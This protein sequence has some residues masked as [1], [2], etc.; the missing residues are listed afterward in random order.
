MCLCFHTWTPETQG[1][2][3]LEREKRQHVQKS[4]WQNCCFLYNSVVVKD[5][6]PSHT[7]TLPQQL[8][9]LDISWHVHKLPLLLMLYY[10][11]A[12]LNISARSPEWMLKTF[13]VSQ[14]TSLE[15]LWNVSGLQCVCVKAAQCDRLITAFLHRPD[16]SQRATTWQSFQC[17]LR[18]LEKDRSRQMGSY[19]FQENF[20]LSTKRFYFPAFD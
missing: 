15:Q 1:N 4:C 3:C 2:R 16:E 13:A 6:L 14:A 8:Q 19:F 17:V 18:K 12:G 10:L 7:Q 20:K 11:G 5:K 9:M